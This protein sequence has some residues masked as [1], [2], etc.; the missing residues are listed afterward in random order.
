MAGWNEDKFVGLL[1]KLIGES[2]HLQNKPPVLVPQESLVGDHVTEFLKP[3]LVENGGVLKMERICYD[4]ENKRN[5]II[6]TYPGPSD[7]VVSFVGSHLDV[8]AANPEDWTK[9]GEY[10]L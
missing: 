6:I 10:I 3:H 2:K 4:K 8:V 1:T 5:N 7:R 9:A